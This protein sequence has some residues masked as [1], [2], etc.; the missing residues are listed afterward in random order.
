MRGPDIRLDSL[1]S[2]GKPDAWVL[3]D[4]SLRTIRTLVD[5]IL[6]E[7]AGDFDALYSSFG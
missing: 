7:L 3:K 4:H 1:F 2:T 6:K 5:V